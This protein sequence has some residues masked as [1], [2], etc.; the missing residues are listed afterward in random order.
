MLQ[1]LARLGNLSVDWGGPGIS[2]GSAPS[3]SPQTRSHPF[4]LSLHVA[5]EQ[6]RGADTVSRFSDLS[7]LQCQRSSQS[8]PP[9]V[10]FLSLLP[11]VFAH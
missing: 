9:F 5:M 10:S 4:W 7:G 3:S 1:V 2:Q 11:P 6:K 8:F